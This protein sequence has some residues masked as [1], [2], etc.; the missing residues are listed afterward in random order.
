MEK[1][2]YTMY[3]IC[4]INRW[5]RHIA[6]S[7]ILLAVAFVTAMEWS[8]RCVAETTVSVGVLYPEVREPYDSIFRSIIE[9]IRSVP[10]I[11]SKDYALTSDSDLKALPGWLNGG[12]FDAVIALGTRCLRMSEQLPSNLPT[13]VGAV[14]MSADLTERHITGIV[15]SPDPD[16]LFARLVAVAPRVR[17]VN[18]VYNPEVN[19]W[20]IS[21]AKKAAIAR[22]I[23]L[24]AL[25]ASSF[26]EAA[27]RLRR[28]LSQS[29]SDL[30]TIWILQDNSIFDERT[31]LPSILKTAWDRRLIVISNTPTDVKRGVLLGLY[32]NNH[33]MGARLGRLAIK[34]AAKGDHAADD[35]GVMPLQD[36]HVA[37]NARTAKHLGLEIPRRDLETYDLVFPER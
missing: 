7:P 20:L 35:P 12:S 22:G 5:T 2:L 1:A 15:L 14:Q 23:S 9:G 8:S 26:R 18:V 11:E 36:L 16:V 21:R 4:A 13:V 27:S 25:P 29:T 31:M 17:R 10:G 33:A 32:P 19:G 28:L 37:I 24:N 3:T 6:F 34:V 30:D